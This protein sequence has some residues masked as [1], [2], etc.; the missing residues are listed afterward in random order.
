MKQYLMSVYH[1]EDQGLAHGDMD[2]IGADVNA[3][4]D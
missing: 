1:P 2:A 4:N 3:L